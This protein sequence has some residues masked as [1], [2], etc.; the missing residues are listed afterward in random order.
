MARRIDLH[1]MTDKDVTFSCTSDLFR[2]YAM[3]SALPLS[4]ETGT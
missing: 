3:E 2:L 4:A 1:N